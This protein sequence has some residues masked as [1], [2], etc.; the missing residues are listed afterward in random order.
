MSCGIVEICCDVFCYEGV[1]H[2]NI[3]MASFRASLLATMGF[4]KCQP[5]CR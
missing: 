3:N 4:R 5:K 2:E 1:A